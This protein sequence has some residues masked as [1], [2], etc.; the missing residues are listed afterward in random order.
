[1]LLEHMLFYL[2]TLQLTKVCIYVQLFCHALS[3]STKLIS[4]TLEFSFGLWRQ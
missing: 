2:L 1:M 4:L 3:M